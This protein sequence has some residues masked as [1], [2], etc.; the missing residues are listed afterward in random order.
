[1]FIVGFIAGLIFLVLV[2]AGTVLYLKYK[3]KREI[4]YQKEF[5]KN[6]LSGIS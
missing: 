3:A 2:D 6:F 4:H 1:M 5:L